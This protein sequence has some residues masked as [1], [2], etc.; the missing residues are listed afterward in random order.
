MHELPGELVG[1]GDAGIPARAAQDRPGDVVLRCRALA[2]Q[3][4]EH[5]IPF[6]IR[7]DTSANETRFT[8]D[9]RNDIRT[10]SNA[11]A[12]RP[13]Q[14]HR[15]SQIDDRAPSIR[16]ERNGP[17]TAG[18]VPGTFKLPPFARGRRG[19]F[20]RLRRRPASGRDEGQCDHHK[21]TQ[22]AQE[23]NTVV[24]A[25]TLCEHL[26]PRLQVMART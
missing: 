22:Y 13:C 7:P 9:K 20:G 26:G 6:L 18:G 4:A 5:L 3:L 10:K 11:G 25:G 2:F 24:A 17:A 19:G 15:P 16:A 1:P 23:T 12:P 21:T 14:Q 8:V